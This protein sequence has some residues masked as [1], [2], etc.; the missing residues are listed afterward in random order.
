MGLR[1]IQVRPCET[2][3]FP[4][5]LI[6]KIMEILMIIT[7]RLITII[8]NSFDNNKRFDYNEKRQNVTKIGGNNEF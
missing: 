1:Q 8:I 2:G 4:L 3:K 6:E 5:R 7:K